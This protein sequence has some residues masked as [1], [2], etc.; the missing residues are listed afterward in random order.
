MCLLH[1]AELDEFTLFAPRFTGFHNENIESGP[2]YLEF[3]AGVVGP[4][5]KP[6]TPQYDRYS[7]DMSTSDMWISFLFEGAACLSIQGTVGAVPWEGS[8]AA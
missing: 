5:C 2:T 7:L 1:R 3:R 6:K 8:E 4:A